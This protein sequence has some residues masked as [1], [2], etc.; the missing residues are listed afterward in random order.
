MSV[1]EDAMERVSNLAG[2]CQTISSYFD[3]QE[4]KL[5]RLRKYGEM[6]AAGEVTANANDLNRATGIMD[7][8][9]AEVIPVS[10]V[11]TS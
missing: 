8:I 7:D 10:G 11:I 4:A 9:E 6:V 2:R 1:L 3:Q 5:T